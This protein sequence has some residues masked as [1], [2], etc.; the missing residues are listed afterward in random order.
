MTEFT[1]YLT[2]RVKEKFLL[3]AKMNKVSLRLQK[4]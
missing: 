1:I 2:L 3:I 4:N